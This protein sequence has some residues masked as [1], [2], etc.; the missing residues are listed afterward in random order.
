[1]RNLNCILIRWVSQDYKGVVVW[2]EVVFGDQ[3]YVV[4]LLHNASSLYKISSHEAQS[5]CGIS[6]VNSLAD[7][8][9][10]I[11]DLDKQEE[12]DAM[13]LYINPNWVVLSV[14][15]KSLI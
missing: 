6:F 9:F 1:M 11:L 3:R 2:N 5:Y 13:Q 4:D 12:K 10:Q 8:P 15:Q 7:Y 14:P